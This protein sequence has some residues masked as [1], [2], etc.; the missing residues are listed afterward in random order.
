[1]I[2]LQKSGPNKE[3]VNHW[4]SGYP[5]IYNLDENFRMPDFGNTMYGIPEA[6]HLMYSIQD[7]SAM[8]PQCCSAAFSGAVHW[9]CPIEDVCLLFTISHKTFVFK[10]W[11]NSKKPELVDKYIEDLPVFFEPME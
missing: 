9:E 2:K 1:M 6:G 11:K 10:E 4:I 7:S 5:N 8:V 3:S